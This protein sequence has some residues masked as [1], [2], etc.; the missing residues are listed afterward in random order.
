MIEHIKT[1]LLTVLILTS[2]YLTWLI[3]T[4]Q[5]EYRLLEP[6]EYIESTEIG[7]EK[8]VTDI[9]RPREIVFHD[10]VRHE[11]LIPGE[12]HVSMFLAELTELEIEQLVTSSSTA[13]SMSQQIGG[14]EFIYPAPI[15]SEDIEQLFDIS[16]EEMSISKVDRI[17]LFVNEQN[18]Q[19]DVSI[20]FISYDEKSVVQGKTDM[21][22][23]D[24]EALRANVENVT[25]PAKAE[26]FNENEESDIEEISY[27]PS[28]PL[29]M[30]RYT[31]MSNVIQVKTF[32]ELMFSDPE[33]VQHYFQGNSEESFSDGNRILNIENGGDVINYVHP[34]LSDPEP[35]EGDGMV[36]ESLDFVNSHGGWTDTYLYDD[37]N[38]STYHENVTFR[39]SISGTP[40]LGSNIGDDR[41]YTMNLQK[42]SGRIEEYT[43]P[44][45]ELEDDPFEFEESIS[46][47][48]AT[49]ILKKLDKSEEVDIDSVDDIQI[50]Q[51]MTKQQSF[52]IFQPQWFMKYHGSWQP[53]PD[54]DESEQEVAGEVSVRGL[55]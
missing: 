19:A 55:E 39:L 3:W 14:F 18:E 37:Y 24:L 13:V 21:T 10:G 44:L 48:P 5:P 52:L 35:T 28:E 7:E 40:V 38:V 8:E 34:V 50:G 26:V 43:R 1:V 49:E 25:V 20:Q 12:D 30:K 32:K 17:V 23:E 2:V 53:I 4:Y 29:E 47:S 41:L 46:L 15:Y 22:F 31:F 6:T 16:E 45:F 11:W 51:H 33:H 36:Q 54:L 9:V 27:F 42:T